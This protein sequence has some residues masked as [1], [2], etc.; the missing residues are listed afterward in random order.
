MCH[1][2]SL[3]NKN[4]LP[5]NASVY[6][7]GK[8][9][10]KTYLDPY[11][12]KKTHNL[13]LSREISIICERILEKKFSSETKIGDNIKL[14]R[15]YILKLK[16]NKD[17]PITLVLVDQIPLSTDKSIDV[18]LIESSQAELN[19]NS[20][21]LIW[22]IILNPNEIIEKKFINKIRNEN[23]SCNRY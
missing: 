6:F 15:S 7:N 11:T 18:Q 1:F 8:S 2:E 22:N 19:K 21:K 12:I 5:G 23:I 13:S 10:G 4:L 16:N 20:G 17:L 14:E 3:G 9:V